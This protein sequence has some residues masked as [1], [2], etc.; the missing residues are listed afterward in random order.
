MDTNNLLTGGELEKSSK[1][2]IGNLK[3]KNG[4]IKIIPGHLDNKILSKRDK[5]L[6]HLDKVLS[7][8]KRLKEKNIKKYFQALGGKYIRN[9][10]CISGDNSHCKDGR[11]VSI[12]GAHKLLKL[13]TK[14]KLN[15]NDSLKTFKGSAPQLYE[16]LE[17]KIKGGYKSIG[18][19]ESKGGERKKR[20]SGEDSY[21]V[22]EEDE[23]TMS[24][25]FSNYGI[26]EFKGD[27]KARNIMINYLRRLFINEVK[28][29]RHHT[30]YFHA[31][32]A[33][34]IVNKECSKGKYEE[35]KDAV[36]DSKYLFKTLVLWIKEHVPNYDLNDLYRDGLSIINN[37]PKI[38]ELFVEK[39]RPFR[40]GGNERYSED[41]HVDGGNERYSEGRLRER[42][43]EGGNERYSEGRPRERYVEGGNE[44]YSEERPRERYVEGGNERYS[45]GRPRERYVDGGNE[46]YSEGRPRERYV[47]GGNERYSENINRYVDGGKE[48]YEGGYERYSENRNRYVED[49]P[50][51]N[52]YYSDSMHG[53]ALGLF[54]NEIGRN[55]FDSSENK[56]R[57]EILG[58]SL[59]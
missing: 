49:R 32:E 25:N 6:Y 33:R 20:I 43:V 58:L 8:G 19:D 23:P 9:D 51:Y 48:R 13:I 27:R 2:Y 21:G 42:F 15:V 56:L 5:I 3:E 47:E 11:S 50:R 34:Y 10:M 46:R 4:G 12:G 30:S 57:N 29:I 28:N 40:N 17:S 35:C 45:E 7:G 52:D 38:R 36:N 37:E 31:L 26:E 39:S 53:G 54:R 14:K 55:L 44:R 41:R 24:N 18:Y 59:D 16:K 1:V 22:V